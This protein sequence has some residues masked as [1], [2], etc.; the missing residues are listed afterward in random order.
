MKATPGWY[1]PWFVAAALLVTVGVNVVIL[2]AARSD[3][4][5]SVVEPDYYRKAVAWDETMVRRA[6][7]DRLGWSATA[8]IERPVTRTDADAAEQDEVL[9][10]IRDEMGASVQGAQASAVLIHNLEA[11]HPLAV[12][13]GEREPGLYVATIA[14]VRAGR[15][16]VRVEAQRGEERFLGTLFAEATATAPRS[17]PPAAKSPLGGLQ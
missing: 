13:L 16:E 14:R 11:G 9:V 5:G 12:P 3:R 1:W 8:R 7:S 4:T 2:V 17:E 15:W 6:A 10:Q